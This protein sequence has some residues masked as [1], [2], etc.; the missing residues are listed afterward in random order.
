MPQ[1]RTR[2]GCR[3]ALPAK[4]VHYD[5]GC[6]DQPPSASERNTTSGDSFCGVHMLDSIRRF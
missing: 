2:A 6:V 3:D 4:M 5:M 1:R